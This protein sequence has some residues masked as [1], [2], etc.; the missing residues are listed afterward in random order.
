MLAANALDGTDNVML[1]EGVYT[2][3][4]G[5][6]HFTGLG[7]L[8]LTGQGVQRL[9]RTTP[10]GGVRSDRALPVFSR[11]PRTPRAAVVS[12][13]RHRRCAIDTA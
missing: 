8:T 3:S 13:A 4:R 2:L 7:Q 12:P 11:W 10:G 5:A 6:L 1:G 9:T